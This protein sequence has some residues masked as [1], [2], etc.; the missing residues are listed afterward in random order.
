[1]DAGDHVRLCFHVTLYKLATFMK[2]QK[3]MVVSRLNGCLDGGTGCRWCV[4]F[5][6]E[7]H[8]R[9]EAV[10]A[11]DLRIG[12]VEYARRPSRYR[13]TGRREDAS[14]L[15]HEHMSTLAHGGDCL[16]P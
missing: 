12:P 10:A 11:I 3:P 2:R 9:R 14:T 4:P 1:M 6:E 5:L 13:A 16:M 7:P 8:R 15:P